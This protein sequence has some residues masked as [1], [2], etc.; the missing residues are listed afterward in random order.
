MSE[1]IRRIWNKRPRET[2]KSYEAFKIYR[3]MGP[4]RS[5]ARLGRE[6]A[7]SKQN[8][9]RWSVSNE[10]VKRVTAYDHY[11]DLKA[12]EAA[13]DEAQEAARRHI[14]LGKLL[15]GRG[16]KVLQGKADDDITAAE[17]TRMV[18]EGTKLERTAMELPDQ[19][20]RQQIVGVA[21]G[22]PIQIETSILTEIIKNPDAVGHLSRAIESTAGIDVP[23]LPWEKNGK[24]N[25]KSKAKSGKKP[26]NGASRKA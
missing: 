16:A 24:R 2:Q 1:D 9:D 13:L 4:T 7:K 5:L 12:Q 17:G 10:W 3:D 22:D 8:F 15:Q 14:R 20:T 21:G 18:V 6:L 25:G 11:L 23:D 26:R 19:I